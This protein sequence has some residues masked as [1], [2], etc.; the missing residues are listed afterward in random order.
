[1][2]LTNLLTLIIAA[3]SNPAAAPRTA[4]R[5][6]L[7]DA[8]YGGLSNRTELTCVLRGALLGQRWIRSNG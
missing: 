3:A 8:V 5:R 2:D 4:R 7:A 1:M 6:S